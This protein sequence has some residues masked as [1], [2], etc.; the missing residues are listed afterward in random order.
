MKRTAPILIP[1]LL[2]AI[3][4]DPEPVLIEHSEAIA[5]A[6]HTGVYI[7]SEGLFNN[8]NSTLAWVDF[9]SGLPDS[10]NTDNGKSYDCF[11]KVNGRRLGDTANDILIYGSRMYIAV[12]VSSTVEILDAATCRSL[13]QISLTHDGKPAEPR[14]MTGH[15][16]YVYVCSL[17]DQLP[18]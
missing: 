7:L 2:A 17:T 9:E 5:D 4:C 6:G 18:V 11:E 3:S 14:Y 16:G 1:I 13:A 10:W 8:N 15:D 12:N